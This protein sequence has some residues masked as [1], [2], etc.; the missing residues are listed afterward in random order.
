MFSLNIKTAVVPPTNGDIDALVEIPEI[1]AYVAA[2]KCG[3]F[4]KQHLDDLASCLTGETRGAEASYIKKKIATAAGLTTNEQ[5]ATF[6]DR[7]EGFKA[8]I[9]GGTVKF[10]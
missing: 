9:K 5:L 4:E 8:R 7:L 6:Y 1:A 3:V 2:I 10:G